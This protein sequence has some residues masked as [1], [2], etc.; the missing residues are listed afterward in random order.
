MGLEPKRFRDVVVVVVVVMIPPG[1]VALM[2]TLPDI[3]EMNAA[4]L[5]IV[6]RAVA[7]V[8]SFVMVINYGYGYGYGGGD[9]E[10]RRSVFGFG[11]G[12]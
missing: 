9:S 1:K 12:D 3:G 6:K 11:F 8:V 10:E 4:A 2:A 5:L 7:R